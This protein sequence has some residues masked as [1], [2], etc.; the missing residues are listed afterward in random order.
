MKNYLKVIADLFYELYD[1]RKFPTVLDCLMV[2]PLRDRPRSTASREARI[3]KNNSNA[4]QTSTSRATKC[5]SI[6]S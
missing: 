2:L 6:P 3:T 5:V 4:L 1:E